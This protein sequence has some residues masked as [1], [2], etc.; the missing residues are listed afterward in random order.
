MSGRKIILPILG[1]CFLLVL[2]ALH[3]ASAAPL[4][5]PNTIT[6]TTNQDAT[7]A[8]AGSLRAA[9]ATANSNPDL[10]VINFAIG[11]G[12]SK[13]IS[14]VKE[15]PEITTPVTIDGTT[16][17]GYSG[18][19][20]IR[21]DGADAV[22]GSGII[23]GLTF[24][25]GSDGSTLRGLDIT[26]FLDDGIQ[27]LDSNND[28]IE[29]NYI[30]TNLAGTAALPNTKEGILLGNELH[31]ANNNTIRNNLISG[32]GG[33]GIHISGIGASG[34]IIQNNK[35]GTDAA[36]T[37]NLGN[38]V[39]GIRVENAPNTTIGGT[40]A[41]QANII[42]FNGDSGILLEL[43]DGN[44]ISRNSIFSNVGLGIQITGFSKENAPLISPNGTP[45]T[46][47]ATVTFTGDPNTQ[48]TFEFFD[49]T[50]CDDSGYG[51]GET[52]FLTQ[53][54]TSD[55][56]GLVS[57]NVS[58]SGDIITATATGGIGG[59]VPSPNPSFTT[60]F[61]PCYTGSAFATRT[62][63]NTAT[64]TTTGTPTN[65][66]TATMTPT[67][68]TFT[69]TP[70]FTPTTTG[71]STRTATS[72]K[73]ATATVTAS[74]T[75]TGITPS[76]TSC[77]GKPPKPH[78]VAPGNGSIVFVRQVPLAWDTVGCATKYQVII[79][80]GSKFGP[81]VQRKT[82]TAPQFTTKQ[83]KKGKTYVWRVRACKASKTSCG[84]WNN[85]S[86]FK[87]SNS[88]VY[89]Y[90]RDDWFVTQINPSDTTYLTN[91]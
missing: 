4:S 56:N 17:T 57:F 84:K 75:P 16:Q 23:S 3:R 68:V 52:Y 5:A 67:P 51:E 13:T 35:I 41:N 26:N 72:T 76:P 30:G 71:T 83:L 65:T 61:S 90:Q 55:G 34:T 14:L 12:G 62:P 59:A 69:P 8:P 20:L 32:N 70:T 2:F 44:K 91:K 64:P 25:V 53:T 50:T 86:K 33:S 6:V 42:A 21:L 45:P 37:G 54:S 39:Y 49:N 66:R 43:R 7:P 19:P 74:R 15:L 36:G 38:T 73:T 85:W 27:V 60:T 88:A 24:H 9:I 28:L 82:I 47:S 29:N 80:L 1:T 48:Y 77:A 81:K 31:T 79:K 22:T 89:N 46:N 10:T 78:S 58:L 87:V 11:T 63:T 40:G 18:T